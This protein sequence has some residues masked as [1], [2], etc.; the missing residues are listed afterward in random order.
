[1]NIDREHITDQIEQ[2]TGHRSDR[3]IDHVIE[4]IEERAGWGWP[5]CFELLACDT[6][7]GRPEFVYASA[8]EE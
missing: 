3:F 6:I 1:M 8:E 2:L 4:S 7:S 5:A